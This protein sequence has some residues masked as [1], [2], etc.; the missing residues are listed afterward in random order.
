MPEQRPRAAGRTCADSLLL[1]DGTLADELA[2]R[3][4]MGVKDATMTLAIGA[5]R[6]GR[7]G[8][9]AASSFSVLPQAGGYSQ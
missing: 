4:V 1:P 2:Y 7:R 3:T 9:I 6:L 8:T 5:R